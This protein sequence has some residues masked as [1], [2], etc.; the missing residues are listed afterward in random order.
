MTNERMTAAQY[1][2]LTAQKKPRQGSA[3]STAPNPY[4][5]MRCI[6]CGQ[7]VRSDSSPA[8]LETVIGPDGSTIGRWVRH[9][10]ACP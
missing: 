8:Q 4:R 9:L 10:G 5:G 1:R 7:L 2:E 6:V 3:R